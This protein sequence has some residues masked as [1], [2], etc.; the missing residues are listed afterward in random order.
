MKGKAALALLIVVVTLVTASLVYAQY[1]F[2]STNDYNAAH[3]LPYVRQVSADVGQV[4]LEFVN[5][6]VALEYFEYRIDGLVLTSGNAHPVVTGDF[7]YPGVLVDSRYTADPV[8]VS[9]TFS[10]RR[11]VEVRLAL[12]GERDWDF[13]WVTF[14]VPDVVSKEQCQEG[15]WEAAGFANQGQCIRFINTG[16]D[17]R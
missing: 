10:A 2:P 4:T 15:L 14:Y 7:E 16:E 13:D 6:T 8:I 5:D 12:G 11:T 17:S 9:Q 3:N 1:M